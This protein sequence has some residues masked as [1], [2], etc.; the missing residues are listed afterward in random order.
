[1]QQTHK[2]NNINLQQF[3]FLV[4]FIL[5]LYF[6][7]FSEILHWLFPLIPSNEVVHNNFVHFSCYS[8][9]AQNAAKYSNRNATVKS[10]K[11]WTLKA[12]RRAVIN[13]KRLLSYA[14]VETGG[15]FRFV[16]VQLERETLAGESFLRLCA[17]ILHGNCICGGACN[18]YSN[19]TDV[20]D[21]GVII[22]IAQK[23]SECERQSKWRWWRKEICVIDS[24]IECDVYR[25]SAQELLKLQWMGN[26]YEPK[27]D[28]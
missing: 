1:M 20:D 24:Q 23:A 3:I 17:N 9:S 15:N 6:S 10:C 5:L 28:G 8:Q 22:R 7:L 13:E 21:D 14:I 25:S 27:I 16:F 11:S 12:P 26:E 19:N 2:Y 18:N 4:V